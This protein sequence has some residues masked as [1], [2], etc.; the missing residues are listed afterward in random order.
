M[1]MTSV[2]RRELTVQLAN[3]PLP[4]LQDLLEAEEAAPPP[5][6]KPQKKRKRGDKDQGGDAPAVK[7]KAKSRSFQDEEFFINAIPPNRVSRLLSQRAKAV[8]VGLCFRP[9]LRQASSVF[10]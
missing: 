10:K 4:L 2:S 6:A 1:L 5:E 3:G 8:L 7:K 9:L